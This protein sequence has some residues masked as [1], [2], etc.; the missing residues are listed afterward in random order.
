MYLIGHLHN[1]VILTRIL[2]GFVSL[3]KL[4][5]LLLKP[6]WEYQI[7]KNMKERNEWILVLDRRHIVQMTHLQNVGIS[8]GGRKDVNIKKRWQN[9]NMKFAYLPG[10]TF[11]SNISTKLSLSVR[12]CSWKKPSACPEKSIYYYFLLVIFFANMFLE[13]LLL[14]KL[15]IKIDVSIYQF[16]EPQCPWSSIPVLEWCFVAFQFFQV[17]RST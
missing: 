9:D 11:L 2:Q 4:G 12:D 1:G 8:S 10:S 5:P 16:R 13:L 6:H 3:F 17:A 7:L 15:M 14:M